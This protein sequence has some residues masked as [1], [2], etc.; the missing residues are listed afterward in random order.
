MDVTKAPVKNVTFCFVL[1][2]N[3]GSGKPMF[4]GDQP[5]DIFVP[6]ANAIRKAGGDFRIAVGGAGGTELAGSVKDVKK[7]ADAYESIIVMYRL[8]CLDLDIEGTALFDVAQNDRRFKAL[9]MIQKKYPLL[10]FDF[11]LPAMPT[12]LPAEAVEFIKLAKKYK[13]RFGAVNPM[14][15]NYGPYYTGDMAKYAI[16]CAN[17]VKAQIDSIGVKATIGMKPMIGN[18]DTVPLKFT[19]QHAKDVIAFARTK[20][21]VSL[22][23]F[24]SLDRDSPKFKEQYAHM[25]LKT[26]EWSY[27]NIFKKFEN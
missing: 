5:L 10:K 21:W 7:L 26:P 23:S 8:T 22:V 1:A 24:W 17:A 2:D 4:N 11:T 3:Q 25:G 12:G 16:Q 27:T 15:M 13:I 20:P 14:C 6:Q 9:A 18:N 19:T